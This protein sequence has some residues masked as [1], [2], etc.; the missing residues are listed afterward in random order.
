M[1]ESALMN[2]KLFLWY[3]MQVETE[4]Q[5]NQW[6]FCLPVLL[7][8]TVILKVSVVLVSLVGIS[9][10]V[11]ECGISAFFSKW[12]LAFPM[13]CGGASLWKCLCVRTGTGVH[14]WLV[15][16][17]TIL[18]WVAVIS[19]GALLSPCNKHVLRWDWHS[20]HRPFWPEQY[21]QV[22][23]ESTSPVSSIIAYSVL[24]VGCCCH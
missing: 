16:A 18:K 17:A 19:F 13:Y 21:E 15:K 20:Q 23:M 6:F 8:C 1:W 24:A 7:L 22:C 5:S 9:L 2:E 14:C 10:D 12:V 3:E 11:A 4:D